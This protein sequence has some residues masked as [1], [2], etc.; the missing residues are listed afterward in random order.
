MNYNTLRTEVQRQVTRLIDIIE[1]TCPQDSNVTVTVEFGHGGVVM[2]EGL[3]TTIKGELLL[4][5]RKNGSW[6]TEYTTIRT[7]TERVQ[8]V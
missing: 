4:L 1:T 5:E 3:I 2:D 7:S 6:V 8:E